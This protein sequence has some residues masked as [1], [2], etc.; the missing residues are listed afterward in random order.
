MN[1]EKSEVPQ[2]QTPIVEG[3]GFVL[4]SGPFLED[5]RPDPKTAVE[6]RTGASNEDAIRKLEEEKER[7]TNL[8]PAEKSAE[9]IEKIDK[10]ERASIA[11][12]FNNQLNRKTEYSETLSITPDGSFDRQKRQNDGLSPF[13]TTL[14][15]INNT[16]DL[17]GFMKKL[18]DESPEL[19]IV[20]NKYRSIYGHTNWIFK[21]NL[22]REIITSRVRICLIFIYG[23]AVNT[24]A[25]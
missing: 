17:Y 12:F 6:M 23:I 24:Q 8:T 20:Y 25:V 10:E 14:Y 18:T 2:N 3:K 4:K 11:L 5:P 22:I 13:I 1:E 16:E 15:S 7:I 9:L 19:N 21:Q